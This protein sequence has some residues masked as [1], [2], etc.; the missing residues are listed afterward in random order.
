MTI[1]YDTHKMELLRISSGIS[2][3][4]LWGFFFHLHK[5]EMFQ[6]LQESRRESRGEN[7]QSH[8]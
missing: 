2:T 8:I 1:S 3:H 6:K 5:M 4:H 7:V